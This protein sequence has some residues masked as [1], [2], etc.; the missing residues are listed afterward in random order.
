[1]TT[2]EFLQKARTDY[3]KGVLFISPFFPDSV[4]KSTGDIAGYSFAKTT[5]PHYINIWVDDGNQP[6][7]NIPVYLDGIWA[8]I[9]KD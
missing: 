7:G 3:K 4:F 5:N 1:M 9:Q 6:Q 2:K 8:E